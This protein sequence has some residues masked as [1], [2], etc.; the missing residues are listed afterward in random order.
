MCELLGGRYGEHIDLYRAISQEAPEAM[1]RRVKQY[2][3]EGYKKFQLKVGGDPDV[4]IERIHATAAELQPGDVL[5]A[6]ANTGWLTPVAHAS[7][8]GK[9]PRHFGVDPTGRWLLAENQD[10][11]TVVVFAIDA[12]TGRLTPTGQS[13]EV[14]APVC[15]VFV[16]IK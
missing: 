11:G 12:A 13:V 6:D 4:D 3:S 5:D 14:P 8:Q 10:S 15:A 7:T 2:R 9:T 16:P 1:A